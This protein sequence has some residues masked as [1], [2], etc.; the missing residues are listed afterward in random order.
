MRTETAMDSPG[1][2]LEIRAMAVRRARETLK[3]SDAEQRVSL[4]REKLLL[5]AA[6]RAE[7]GEPVRVQ[8][9][10]SQR[11]ATLTAGSDVPAN[12]DD[13]SAEPA[14][15]LRPTVVGYFSR[16]GE[17]TEINNVLEGHFIEVVRR[18]AFETSFTRERAQIKSQ[19]NHGHD[20]R[21]GTMPLGVLDVLREDRIGAW[22]ELILSRTSVA[23]DIAA[24]ATDGLLGSS[25]RFSIRGD[26]G[27]RWSVRAD[28][29]PQREVRDVILYE[30]GPVVT[31]AYQG[32]GVT[33]Q[34]RDLTARP[35]RLTR[36]DIERGRAEV[37]AMVRA[38]EAREVAEY[39]RQAEGSLA[40]AEQRQAR[41]ARR[42]RE[43][44][45][46]RNTGR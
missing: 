41:T 39:A 9:P 29:M 3:L 25:F 20:P 10:R 8:S 37:K 22:Y 45:A 17:P 12:A 2:Q 46:A 6:T 38:N 23:D 42:I 16:F 43:E 7:A 19:F 26:E 14:A 30:L 4:E 5:D 33:L 34:Y 44:R 27:E 11:A 32:T 18:G 21:I 13:A 1:R 24:L 40:V 36:D 35:A 31:P 15:A 28:G